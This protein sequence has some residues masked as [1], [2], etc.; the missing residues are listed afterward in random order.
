MKSSQWYQT[1]SAIMVV[2]GLLGCLVATSCPSCFIPVLGFFWIGYYYS[3]WA[4]VAQQLEHEEQIELD[5][6]ERQSI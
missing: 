2:L 3:E 5:N 1:M 6:Y 4:A